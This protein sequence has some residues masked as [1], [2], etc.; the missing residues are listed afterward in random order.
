MRHAVRARLRAARRAPAD[1]R[2]ADASRPLRQGVRER[3]NSSNTPCIQGSLQEEKQKEHKKS[4]G[5]SRG[6]GDKLVAARCRSWRVTSRK[7]RRPARGRPRSPRRSGT[8]SACCASRARRRTGSGTSRG[9]T[10]WTSRW[11]TARG[12]Y[13]TII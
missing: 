12:P 11:S 2:S 5:R 8:T 4:R 6:V 7:A 10:N 13:Y 3:R 1:A 9:A